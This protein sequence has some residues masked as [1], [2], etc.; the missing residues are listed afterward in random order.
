MR[1][2]N[3]EYLRERKVIIE[4]AGGGATDFTAAL[5]VWELATQG[6]ASS[7]AASI[8]DLL[9]THRFG[10]ALFKAVLDF[11]A[12]HHLS[13]HLVRADHLRFLAPFPGPARSL[14]WRA[15]TRPTRRRAR[16]RFRTSRSSSASQTPQ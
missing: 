11:V 6:R 7:P 8:Q 9:D 12:T 10:T 14:P 13:E 5:Q 2:A 4:G 3:A 16:C 1:I 15:I